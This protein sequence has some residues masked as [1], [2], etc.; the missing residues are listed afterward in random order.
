MAQLATERVQREASPV[1]L[2]LTLLPNPIYDYYVEAP[3]IWGLDALTDQQIAGVI[4]TGTEMVFFFAVF[5]YFVR[6]FFAEE[7]EPLPPGHRTGTS[8][9]PTSLSTCKSFSWVCP[10]K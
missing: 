6:R 2:S 7:D 5:A 4:M 3:R 8:F 10:S 1:G 9:T